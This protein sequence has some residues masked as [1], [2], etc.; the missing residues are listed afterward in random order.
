MQ[1]WD[2]FPTKKPKKT[3]PEKQSYFLIIKQGSKVLLEKREDNGLWGGLFA[4][5]QFDTLAEI[6]RSLNDKNLPKMQQLT[7]FRHTFSHFHLDI[8]PILVDLDLQKT[9][10]IAPLNVAEQQGV[11]RCNIS[12]KQDYWYD[13]NEP[14]RIG[15]ATP[16]K[17]ILD[18]L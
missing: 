10:N 8:I 14:S 2:Q 16:I 11:Y 1:L 12:L 9:D 6:K 5:P 4:F 17:R 18:E 3:L 13:L 15:L 7:A